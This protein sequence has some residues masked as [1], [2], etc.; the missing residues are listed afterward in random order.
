[1]QKSFEKS[2]K[3]LIIGAGLSG[4]SAASKLIENGFKNVV[5]LEAENRIGGRVHCDSFA[6][7]VVDLG[8]QFVHGEKGNVIFDLANEHSA[9]ILPEY[10]ENDYFKSND[11]AVN[12]EICFEIDKKFSNWMKDLPETRNESVGGLMEQKRDDIVTQ[13]GEK[14][15]ELISE[16]CLRY[17]KQSNI[18]FASNSWQDVS[19]FYK[20]FSQECEGNQMIFWKEGTFTKVLDFIMV[21][22][23]IKL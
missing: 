20:R 9:L 22:V 15:R 11:E 1:M 18:G 8:A 19:T 2:P 10:S 3:I 16:M 13:L 5:I 14:D 4:I 23:L 17:E 12:Q 21:N 7:G 6:G